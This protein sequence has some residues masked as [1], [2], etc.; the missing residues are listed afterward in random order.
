MKLQE[1]VNR[2]RCEE[3]NSFNMSAFKSVY[4]IAVSLTKKIISANGYYM[5]QSEIEKF[6]NENQIPTIISFLGD[7]GVG[8]SSA[9]LSFAH[10]LQSYN[11]HSIKDADAFWLSNNIN[12]YVLPKVDATMLTHEEGL[13]DVVL[14]KMWDVFI[15]KVDRSLKR[16]ATQEQVRRKFEEVKQAYNG[17][18]A[19]I[20]GKNVSQ[21]TEL[22]EL[23]NSLNL[24]EAFC[25][26][27]DVFSR[28]M[29]D[30][31]HQKSYIVFAIDDLD[32]VIKNTYLK[33]EELRLLMTIPKVVVLITADLEHLSLSIA[34]TWQ[35][36][37]EGSGADSILIKEYAEKYLAKVL[38][39]NM[40]IFLPYSKKTADAGL[41]EEYASFID[42]LF[43]EK[44]KK[45]L[46]IQK[47]I[48]LFIRKQMGMSLYYEGVSEVD[49]G[50]SLRDTVNVLAELEDIVAEREKDAA[51]MWLRKEFFISSSRIKESKHSEFIKDVIEVNRKIFDLRL[52]RFFLRADSGQKREVRRA[53]YGG[54]IER[55]VDLCNENPEWY[56]FEKLLIWNYGLKVKE[57]LE[58]DDSILKK[59]MEEECFLDVLIHNSFKGIKQPESYIVTCFE[60][61][62]AYKGSPDVI[63][64]ELDRLFLTL[65]FADIKKIL[66]NVTV[67]E[68]IE[69]DESIDESVI[70]DYSISWNFHSASNSSSGFYWVF[71]NLMSFGE[72]KKAFLEWL[73]RIWQND[74][75]GRMEYEKESKLMKK[76]EQRM[77]KVAGKYARLT[78]FDVV[79]LQNIGIIMN[80]VNKLNAVAISGDKLNG[81]RECLLRTARTIQDVYKE[82]SD[83]YYGVFKT[84]KNQY[85]FSYEELFN[86]VLSIIEMEEFSKFY[87]T[88]V[89][90]GDKDSTVEL[91]GG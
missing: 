64:N 10:F 57:E 55:L 29:D 37:L 85:V 74:L 34:S 87:F 79:P 4:E 59:E 72:S 30:D 7:R 56:S 73:K 9:M 67:A 32:M 52:G 68:V 16:E 86:E 65:L 2:I 78:F 62:C 66:K 3:Y 71:S 69:I 38:P 60:N 17:F 13:F 31:K 41:K 1:Y 28:Y 26:L 82:S 54:T 80:I 48:D 84:R 76:M 39:R 36:Q 35:K 5:G 21:L 24:R 42:R 89:D 58:S 49:T 77:A 63:Y 33:L 18:C 90:K 23:S 61:I 88:S 51:K 44:P 22:H 53:G 75:F 15:D 40:R 19:D 47:V 50:L 43:K 83:Y 6:G 11:T 27:V 45:D 91:L 14:A 46:T 20:K 70:K 81:T 25:Q 8:K 12:F